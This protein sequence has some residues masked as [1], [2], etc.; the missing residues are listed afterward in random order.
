MGVS[1]ELAQKRSP[2]AAAEDEL[3]AGEIAIAGVDAAHDAVGHIDGEELGFAEKGDAEGFGAFGDL[4]DGRN[5]ADDAVAG[6]VDGAEDEVGVEL[7][8]EIAG[9]GGIEETGV[10][11]P[12]AGVA[13]FAFQ[14]VPAFGGGGDFEAAGWEPGGGV[15]GRDFGEGGGGPLG[16]FGDRAGGV[17]LKDAAGGVRGG[18]AG[19]EERGAVDDQDIGAAELG[20]LPGGG[21]A[22]DAGAD[23]DGS[24][25]GLHGGGSGGVDWR[26][27]VEGIMRPGTPRLGTEGLRINL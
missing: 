13:D 16:E 24:E 14:I 6:D 17:V 12:G 25:V 22:D 8:E 10:E 4:L 27:S 11:P 18:A 15:G 3:V 19:F 20:Q 5:G 7:G 26:V 21:D 1:V 2:D 23:D 9:F